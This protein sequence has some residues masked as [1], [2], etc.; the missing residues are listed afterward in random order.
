MPET[1]VDPHAELV[2]PLPVLRRT[3]PEDAG[4]R[5]P[6][7]VHHCGSQLFVE[8]V[9]CTYLLAGGECDG[10]PDVWKVT[11]LNGHV[12][13]LGDD[14]G[15]EELIPFDLP[16]VQEAL[17]GIGVIAKAGGGIA[18]RAEEVDQ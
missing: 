17:E 3:W 15:N 8:R 18:L 1:S 10:A 14:D 2:C 16:L 7:L 6:L 4:E 12:L 11:C 9:G 13:L 5:G